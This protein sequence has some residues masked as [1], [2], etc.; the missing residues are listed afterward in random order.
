[1]MNFQLKYEL[2]AV[3]DGIILCFLSA[4]FLVI[5]NKR[6]LHFLSAYSSLGLV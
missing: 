2:L 4:L 5:F 6:M 3:F 1:M